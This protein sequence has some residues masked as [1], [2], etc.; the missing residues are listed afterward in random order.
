MRDRDHVADFLAE[1]QEGINE[2]PLDDLTPADAAYI[3]TALRTVAHRRIASTA[4]SGLRKSPN[5]RL[6][7]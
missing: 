6:V 3:L 4:A 5:L 7:R 1:M 2:L